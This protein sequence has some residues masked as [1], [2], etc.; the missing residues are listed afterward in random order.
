MVD[1][2]LE[3]ALTW[4]NE[5]KV[6][7]QLDLYNRVDKK[8]RKLSKK[9]KGVIPDDNSLRKGTKHKGV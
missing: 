7:N 1:D 5:H 2:R 6:K 9:D 4:C 8:D 3:T